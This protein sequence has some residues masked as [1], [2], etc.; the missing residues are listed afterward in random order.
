MVLPC[1]VGD[2][3][4]VVE[5]NEIKEMEVEHIKSAPDGS[6]CMQAYCKYETEYC[7][8]NGPCGIRFTAE[9]MKQRN[10]HFT[11]EEAEA[12]LRRNDQNG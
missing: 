5:K 7:Y 8:C 1:K 2:T 11:R 10:I 9:N 3:I 6:I 4:F 12:A